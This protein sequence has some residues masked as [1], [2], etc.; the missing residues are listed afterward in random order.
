VIPAAVYLHDSTSGG[1]VGPVRTKCLHES[2]Q[3]LRARELPH[4]AR[5]L[6]HVLV[7][8]RCGYVAQLF[9]Q[10][11]QVRRPRDVLFVAQQHRH[12]HELPQLH[13]HPCLKGLNFRAGAHPR[14]HSLWHRR[15]EVS[16]RHDVLYVPMQGLWER[17]ADRAE[18]GV[19]RLVLE[20]VRS[21]NDI[22]G[23][24]CGHADQRQLVAPECHG[25]RDARGRY[26]VVLKPGVK[27]L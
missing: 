17:V 12:W 13:L 14:F 10:P 24:E 9:V 1:P 21:T 2:C 7:R 22:N 4:T 20:L 11:V 8:P 3:V 23:L 16:H 18:R 15:A 25:D 19:I 26:P 6:K 5:N 27:E